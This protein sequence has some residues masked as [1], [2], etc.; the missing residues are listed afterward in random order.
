MAVCTERIRWRRQRGRAA[1]LESH[2]SGVGACLTHLA[3]S[4]LVASIVAQANWRSLVDEECNLATNSVN[5][6]QGRKQ[7]HNITSTLERG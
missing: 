5:L 3:T 1:A 7:A 4:A 2:E 6:A